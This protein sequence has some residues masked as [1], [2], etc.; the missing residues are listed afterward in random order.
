MPAGHIYIL[1]SPGVAYLK[2]GCTSKLPTERSRELYATGNPF[3][4]AVV[5]SEEVDDI[6]GAES[7]VHQ[8][9]DKYRVNKNREFF[10]VSV[11]E[12]IRVVSEIA[13]RFQSEKG[14]GVEKQ[15][16]IFRVASVSVEAPWFDSIHSLSYVVRVGGGTLS[17]GE[18]KRAWPERVR[19]VAFMPV[20][21][22]AFEAWFIAI[23]GREYVSD[24]NDLNQFVE[25]DWG[26]YGEQRT[27][28][29]YRS[30]N[31]RYL[32]QIYR[33]CVLGQQVD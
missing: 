1:N 21:E 27:I 32:A 18:L 17:E 30:S 24:Q 9:L 6:Y 28:R 12:A 33:E 7:A 15:F 29:P 4:F 8:Q 11:A 13:P 2:I 25:T 10:E 31:L 5:H 20:S 3:P 16:A 22:G 23:R 14:K 26:W 19:V